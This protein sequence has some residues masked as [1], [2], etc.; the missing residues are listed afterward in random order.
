MYT[1]PSHF[2]GTFFKIAVCLFDA[3]RKSGVTSRPIL[4]GTVLVR[5]RA[6]FLRLLADLFN[7]ISSGRRILM[8]NPGYARSDSMSGSESCSGCKC[9]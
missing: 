8:N 9:K 4:L 1:V 3:R 7:Q 2:L 5:Q 6:T